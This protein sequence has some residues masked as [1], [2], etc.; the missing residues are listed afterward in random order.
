MIDEFDHCTVIPSHFIDE[1]AAAKVSERCF[2]VSGNVTQLADLIIG[3]AKYIVD[4]VAISDERL[5][6]R[7]EMIEFWRDNQDMGFEVSRG[8]IS[9]AEIETERCARASS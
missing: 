1:M 7:I 8:E 2:K 3:V 5:A 9:V 6:M 4:T